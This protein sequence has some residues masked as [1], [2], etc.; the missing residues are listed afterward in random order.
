MEKKHFTV[1]EV[2]Q[3]LRVTARTLHYYEEVGLIVPVAR[4]AGGHRLYDEHVIQKLRHILRLKEHLGFSLQEIRQVLD[5]ETMLD[6]LRLT[7]QGDLTEEERS[8]V[9]NQYME[10]LRGLVS[11][12]DGKLERLT[13]IREGFVQRLERTKQLRKEREESLK[14]GKPGS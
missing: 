6:E 14:Q 7:Y 1:D 11:Q 8:Q 12:I 5:A 13:E 2:V 10:L 3:Q 4:T 9:L